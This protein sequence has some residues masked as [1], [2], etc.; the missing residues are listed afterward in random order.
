MK[1]FFILLFFLISS[2][3]GFTSEY[4]IRNGLSSMGQRAYT[5]A[6]KLYNSNEN[7]KALDTINSFMKTYSSEVHGLHYL[8]LG[9]I[10]LKQNKEELAFIH[11]KKGALFLKSYRPLWRKTASIAY[12]LKKYDEVLLCLKKMDAIS[13]LTFNEQQLQLTILYKLKRWQDATIVAQQISPNMN[14]TDISGYLYALYKADKYEELIKR[15]K[16]QIG[17]TKEAKWWKILAKYSFKMKHT[18]EGLAAMKTYGSLTTLSP[19]DRRFL[20]GMLLKEKIYD[21]ALEYMLPNYESKLKCKDFVIIGYLYQKMD[22]LE[23]AIQVYKEGLDSGCNKGLYQRIGKIYFNQ[24]KYSK[25]VSLFENGYKNGVNKNYFAYMT[26]ISFMKQNNNQ[27]TK[28]W[29][30]KIT[31]KS[32]FRKSANKILRNIGE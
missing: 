11:L 26:A 3:N 12:E 25:A 18:S 14:E 31:Q 2:F 32:K 24:K 19:E 17:K 20:A 28:V 13:P 29:L 16:D 10:Y 9:N 23:K 1:L 21:E 7:K 30:Q 4:D 6:A 27:Q 8:L 5:R 22:N 15:I